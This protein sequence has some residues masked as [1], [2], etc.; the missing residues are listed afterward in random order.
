[1]RMSDWNGEWDQS[2][3]CAGFFNHV[4]VFSHP[5]VLRG[6]IRV[7]VMLIPNRE[8]MYFAQ[9]SLQPYLAPVGCAV[10]EFHV[11]QRTKEARLR[12]RSIWDGDFAKKDNEI[13]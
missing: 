10:T 11:H 1:M 7:L 13:G 12:D 3:F 8:E 2:Y 4:A 6:I 9:R 5:H